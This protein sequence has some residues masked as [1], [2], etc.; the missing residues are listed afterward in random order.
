VSYVA[1]LCDLAVRDATPKEHSAVRAKGR[2]NNQEA[3]TA[4]R[5]ATMAE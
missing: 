1:Q 5:S 4:R 2:F 3:S